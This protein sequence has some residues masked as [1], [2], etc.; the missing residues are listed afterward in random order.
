VLLQVRDSGELHCYYCGADA[1]Q[2]CARCG[3][4]Y[5]EDHGEALC[6]RCQDPVLA[7]PSYRVYRGS[8]L[9]LLIGTVFAVWLLVKPPSTSDADGPIA[10]TNAPANTSKTTNAPAGTVAGPETKAPA[11]APA[12]ETPAPTPPPAA[13]ATPKASAPTEYTV[14]P[15][16]TLS[17]IATR[18]APPGRA[19]ATYQQ[20]I[21][22]LN[23]LG[24]SGTIN[25][26]QVLRLPP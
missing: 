13:T 8:L 7:L 24:A 25:V 16:D 5:C 14:A 18:F 12:A 20:E 2:E 19:P 21:A 11:P 10:T 6:Q 26:G 9:A 4:L 15:G 22:T 17:A 23:G 1:T 3:A